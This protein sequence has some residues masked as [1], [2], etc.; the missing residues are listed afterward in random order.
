[1]RRNK[2]L[3]QGEIFDCGMESQVM[4]RHGDEYGKSWNADSNGS[5][6]G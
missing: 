4:E 6:I 1:M 2:P 5:S 3:W